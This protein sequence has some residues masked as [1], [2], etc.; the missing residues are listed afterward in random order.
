MIIH[1][2]EITT[3]ILDL[4]LPND[5]SI[6][7]SLSQRLDEYPLKSAKDLFK[8]PATEGNN[9]KTGREKGKTKKF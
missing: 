1:L 3:L 5:I 8:T 7:L 4:V 9:L 6:V 2:K